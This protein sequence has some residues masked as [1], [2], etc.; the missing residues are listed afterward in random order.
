V[1]NGHRLINRSSRDAVFLEA[2]TR[3]PVDVVDYPDIDMRLARDEKG[4]GYAHK[5]GTPYPK[6]ER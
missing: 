4:G 3:A 1:A 6:S 2:G 5:D